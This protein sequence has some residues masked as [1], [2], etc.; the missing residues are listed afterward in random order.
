[1]RTA[2]LEHAVQSEGSVQLVEYLI[3]ISPFSGGV[4]LLCKEEAMFVRLYVT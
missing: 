4:Y 2:I 3:C 1:M